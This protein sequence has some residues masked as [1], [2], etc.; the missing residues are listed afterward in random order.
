MNL[1]IKKTALVSLLTLQLC[2]GF[3]QN[4][5]T[6]KILE[7]KAFSHE[8]YFVNQLDLYQNAIA[9]CEEYLKKDSINNYVR[10]YLVYNQVNLLRIH[11]SDSVIQ[12]EFKK[13]KKSFY[14]NLNILG[15][16]KGFESDAYLMFEMMYVGLSNASPSDKDYFGY[17]E[18]CYP[19]FWYAL[20]M[21]ENNPRF[22][23]QSGIW[24]LYRP[25]IHGGSIDFALKNFNKAVELFE[26][27]PNIDNLKLD[28]GFYE[29]NTYIAEALTEQNKLVEAK[30]LYDMVLKEHPN[31]SLI[32]NDLMPR[33]E[34]KMTKN[35]AKDATWSSTVKDIDGNVYGTVQIGTQTWM[36]ENLK[37]THYNNGDVIPNLADS[38]AWNATTTGAYCWYEN[39]ISHKETNGAL[40]NWYVTVDKRNVCPNGWHAPSDDEFSTLI[41]YLGGKGIAG[42]KMKEEGITHWEK[43]NAWSDNISGFTAIPA[44]YRRHEGH[45]E[46]GLF[47]S[48]DSNVTWW[49]STETKP[50]TA[51]C[52]WIVNRYRDALSDVYSKKGGFSV[53]CVKD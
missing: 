6:K 26:K 32:N 20:R 48:V 22:Y 4:E 16:A 23:I 21:D 18:K 37:T 30:K 41:N 19:Y 13:V 10:S 49:T 3:T 31:Y 29:A 28:W 53:R 8:A 42:S 1:K 39:N 34:K 27:Y 7:L 24:W 46:D 51:I 52:R 9:K 36:K 44:G 38:L 33:L 35:T 45:N 25:E 17:L 14:S 2:A 5:N 40:Y 43:P 12:K 15:D 11:A 50:N 47:Y